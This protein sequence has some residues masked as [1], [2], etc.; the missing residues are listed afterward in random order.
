MWQVFTKLIAQHL[1]VSES[2]VSKYVKQ[3]KAKMENLDK[4]DINQIAESNRIAL[5]LEDLNF[6]VRTNEEN[7]VIYEE[8]VKYEWVEPAY[9]GLALAKTSKGDLVLL[10]PQAKQI[11]NVK[12]DT[13]QMRSQCFIIV[14]KK[15][16]SRKVINNSRGVFT[17][18]K[19]KESTYGFK[20]L[21]SDGNPAYEKDAEFIVK[22]LLNDVLR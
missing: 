14:D 17:F 3:Y 6:S 15:D 12:I 19:D 8:L 13:Y 5:H 9:C 18:V 21:N 7:L 20:V 22:L 16:K 11:P 10:D 4:V 2:T 1:D